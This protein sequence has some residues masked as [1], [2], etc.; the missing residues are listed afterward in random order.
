LPILAKAK[1]AARRIYRSGIARA[2]AS[3][4][5]S[6]LLAKALADERFERGATLDVLRALGDRAPAYGGAAHAAFVRVAA[7]AGSFRNRFLLI[8]PA[9]SLAPSDGSASAFLRTA[10]AADPDARIRAEA[11]RSVRD[12]R[13]FYAELARGLDDRAVRVR[14]AAVTAISAGRIDESA[15]A[16]AYRLKMDAWPLVRRAAARALAELSG[17][18]SVDG[19]LGD[20]LLDDSPEVRREVLRAIGLRHAAS[21]VDKVRDRFQDAGEVDSVRAAAAIA[22]GKLCDAASVD[23]LTK[24]A[25]KLATPMAD[26][27]DRMIGRGALTALSNIA[28]ADLKAR[29]Q[30]FFAKGVP[31]PITELAT[32]A[33]AAPAGCRRGAASVGTPRR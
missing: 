33:L 8:G 24:R 13:A 1:N 14:E 12:P 25:V 22:L 15:P 16:L 2:A 21:Q 18:P 6:G 20:A 19:D 23:A 3:P 7:D 29:L 5:A 9:A 26:E 30:P 28:P 4:E 10:I 27:A 11:S 17:N 32:G 31:K